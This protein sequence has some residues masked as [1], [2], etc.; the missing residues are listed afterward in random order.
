MSRTFLAFAVAPLVPAVLLVRDAGPMIAGVYSY[1]LTYLFGVPLFLFLRLKKKE[2]HARYALGGA[3]SAASVG[4]VIF[5]LNWAEPKLLL[6]TAILSAA[7][8]IEGLCFSA[9]RGR[10]KAL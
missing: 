6:L 2:S 10:E 7:G 9:I 1:F 8:A 4:L 5:L 3:A